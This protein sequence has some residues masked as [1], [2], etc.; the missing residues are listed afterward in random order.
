MHKFCMPCLQRCSL[1]HSPPWTNESQYKQ[2]S[3]KRGSNAASACPAWSAAGPQTGFPHCPHASM[4]RVSPMRQGMCPMS[5]TR[6]IS[7]KLS[8]CR[9]SSSDT[10]K[11][12]I[13][14]SSTVSS[15]GLLPSRTLNTPRFSP[16]GMAATLVAPAVMYPCISALGTLLASPCSSSWVAAATTKLSWAFHP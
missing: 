9:M 8:L 16:Q 5:N 3:F 2:I 15:T 14:G 12:F 11:A 1:A 7:A 10:M 13:I 6:W 4:L